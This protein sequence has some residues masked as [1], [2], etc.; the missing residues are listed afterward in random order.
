MVSDICTTCFRDS[1][2]IFDV[3]K[4][5]LISPGANRFTRKHRIGLRTSKF[6]HVT[7]K[8]DDIAMCPREPVGPHAPSERARHAMKSALNDAI[9]CEIYRYIIFLNFLSIISDIL[10]IGSLQ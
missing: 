6:D 1:T 5:R 10:F 7:K 9:S 3:I 4:W 8:P 2:C